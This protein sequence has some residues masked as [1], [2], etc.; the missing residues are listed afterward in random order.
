MRTSLKKIIKE[1]FHILGFDIQKVPAEATP[2]IFPEKDLSQFE[3]YDPSKFGWL[4]SLNIN[5][6]LDIG[7][8]FGEFASRIRGAL[9]NAQVLAFEPLHHVFRELESNLKEMQ[10]FRAFNFAIG[11]ENAAVTMYHNEYSAS[12]SI[13]KMGTLHK[14]EFPFTAHQTPEIV[15]V[16]RLD[17][18]LSELEPEENI[19]IKIDVQGY[20]DKVIKGGE[21]AIKRAKVLIVETSFY[22]LYEGQPLFHEIYELLVRKGF[23]YVGNLDQLVSPVDGRLLQADAI[24]LNDQ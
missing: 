9:P 12:S 6:V 17:D 10:N 15:G 19:L 8:H 20:E 1:L 22:T 14:V 4:S 23:K 13:L 16:K 21:N 5:T 7:A 2:A 3:P 18:V 11:D 24:F